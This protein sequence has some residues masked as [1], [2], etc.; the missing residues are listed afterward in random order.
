MTLFLLVWPE[1]MVTEDRGTFK[2]LAKNLMQ[3]SLAR[4]STGGVV[5]ETFRVSPSSPVMAFFLARGWTLMEKLTLVGFVD[6]QHR[7]LLSHYAKNPCH[8]ERSEE[9]MHSAGAG[10]ECIGPS[11]R[12]G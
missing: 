2:S 7:K 11:L 12:S 9:P 3:A 1:A 6:R 8:S 10:A 5:S 4:P